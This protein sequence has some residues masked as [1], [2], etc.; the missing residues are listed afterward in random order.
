MTL[1]LV[2]DAWSRTFRSRAVPYAATMDAIPSRNGMRIFPEQAATQWPAKL[3]LEPI[4]NQPPAD[5]LDET[6]NQITVRY[7][8]DTARFVAMQLEYTRQAALKLHDG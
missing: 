7:G 4:G 3:L 8:I 5:A 1:A 2:A 6:L